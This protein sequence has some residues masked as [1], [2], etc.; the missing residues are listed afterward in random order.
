VAKPEGKIPLGRP[1]C[2]IILKW[3]VKKLGWGMQS[4]LY[5]AQDWN[6]WAVMNAGMN[7]MDF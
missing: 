7:I 6:K 1:G 2:R 4:V 3:V 5:V